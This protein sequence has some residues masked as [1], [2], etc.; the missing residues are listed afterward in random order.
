MQLPI[1]YKY[2]TKG[3]P[4]QWQI[5]VEG[6]TFYTLEGLVG[7]ILSPSSPK[8]CNPKN[9]GKSNETTGEEQAILE[10]KSKWQKKKDANY[11]EVLTTDKNFLE[12]MLAKDVKDSKF[13]FKVKTFIQPKLDGV[14]AI[15]KNSELTSRN[16]KSYVSCPHLIVPDLCL[17]GEMYNHQ[18]HDDFNQII[19]LVKKTKP[20][21]ED[22]ILSEKLIQY[23]VY[24]LP[25]FK[26]VF[27]QRNAELKRLKNE[28]KLPE[29]IILVPTY[30]VKNQQEIEHFHDEFIRLGFE[31]S[32]IRLDL[33]DYEN[34]RSNQL[35]KKK[36]FIDE[37]FTII[38]VLEGVGNREGSAGSIL[39][40][41]GDGKTFK[42]SIKGDWDYSRGLWIDQDKLIGKTATVRY[43]NRTPDNI[44]RFPYCTKIFR[45]E[46]E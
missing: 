18:F 23:W 9:V 35:L 20:T 44:P 43:F 37:E 2:T 46:Y 13:I 6:D 7:G 34:K 28:N 3:Q 21:K 41:L 12:P 11:N 5:I 36:D 45:E 39:M 30:E 8:K 25:E 17:D 33:G 22:I 4:Q 38:K 32:I 24:D 19:S 40:D 26:G 42:A 16:G 10:A 31:G 27:S 15:N 29:N 14:R 1:L